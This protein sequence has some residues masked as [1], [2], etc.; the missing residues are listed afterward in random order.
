MATPAGERTCV[1]VRA[2]VRLGCVQ[3]GVAVQ[4]GTRQWNGSDDCKVAAWGTSRWLW[5]QDNHTFDA[6]AKQLSRGRWRIINWADDP[7]KTL[8]YVIQRVRNAWDIEGPTLKRRAVARGPDGAPAGLF[9]LVLADC[10]SK[11]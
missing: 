6:A 11:R 10:L 4:R 3:R 5:L 2:S 9:A 7:G 8:G 1:F